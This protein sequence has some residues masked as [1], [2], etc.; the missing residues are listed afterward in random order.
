MAADTTTYVPPR[1]R[2]LRHFATRAV[3]GDPVT[4][5]AQAWTRAV[6]MAPGADDDTVLD[7]L[8]TEWDA[9][10]ADHPGEPLVAFR[11]PPALAEEPVVPS[12]PPY[13]ALPPLTHGR[14]GVDLPS[15]DDRVRDEQERLAKRD[16]SF[17]GF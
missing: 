6:L 8:R 2:L 11:P 4:W 15:H 12:P 5:L 3:S 17:Y 14:Y 10:R 9:Y 13:D 16:S 7:L 1:D